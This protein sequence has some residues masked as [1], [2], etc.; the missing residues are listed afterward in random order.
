VKR[1][2]ITGGRGFL[3]QNLAA[4]LSHHKEWETRVFDR[5]DSASDFEQCLRGAD[6][7][8]HL[9]GVNR[10][11]DPRDFEVGNVELTAHMC[12]FLRNNG[13]TPKI[14]FSSSIQAKLTNPYG[15]SKAKAEDQLRKFAAETGACVRIYRLKNLF[16]KWCRPNY[17]SVTA[18]FCHN[19]AHDLPIEVSDPA[20]ELELSYVDD[21]VAEFLAEV[22]GTQPSAL[23]GQEITGYRIQLGDLAGR[24]QAF[25]ESRTNLILPDFNDCFNRALYATYLSYVPPGD[26]QQRLDIKSDARGSL[27]EFAKQKHF[28]QIFVS[29]TKPGVTRGNHYHHTKA[30]KFLVIG[31]NGLIRM[32]SINGGPIQEYSV[33]GTAYQVINIPPGFTHSIENVGEGEMITLFWSSELFDPDRPDTYYLPVDIE[34]RSIS[35]STER[36]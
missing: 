11:L 1:I 32:R 31:G 16:G 18:T 27:A 7:I 36:A 13:R 34:E 14:I 6:V 21:V 8:F 24:I 22:D 19:I 35:M 17:N 30:E 5:E 25:H 3:G 2:L 33:S 23:G 15:A 10:P 29:R 20:H 9:A 12:R 26:L 4:H 28:G